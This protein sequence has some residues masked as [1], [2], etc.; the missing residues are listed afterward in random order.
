MKLSEDCIII[1][2]YLI[3]FYIGF[4][5]GLDISPKPYIEP[6][7]NFNHTTKVAIPQ[8]NSIKGIA[9]WYDYDLK[10]LDQKCL[11]N[12]CWSLT[13]NTCASRRFKKG[14][15]L[16]VK[17][18]D[19]DKIIECYVNDYG[20]EEST[21]REIDLSS[22]AFSRLALLSTGVINVEIYERDTKE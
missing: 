5:F 4:S 7:I 8:I 18:L 6:E 11:D 19:N 17:N 21:G 14:K 16:I 9:S 3:I 2:G 22:H 1:I 15:T 12:T 20:P 13:H 10:R